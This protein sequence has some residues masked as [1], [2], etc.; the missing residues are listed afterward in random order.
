[1]TYKLKAPNEKSSHQLTQI[2]HNQAR[3][4]KADLASSF[5]VL[6]DI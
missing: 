1:M 3:L 6:M 2:Q 5:A 4:F